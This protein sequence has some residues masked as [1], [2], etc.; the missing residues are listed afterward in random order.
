MATPLTTPDGRNHP[1][2][3]AAIPPKKPSED[4]VPITQRSHCTAFQLATLHS[5][6]SDYTKR[7]RPDLP[8]PEVAFC[9]C[10][11]R[12]RSFY[13]L[14][15]D[16][17]RFV[18]Q[19]VDLFSSRSQIARVPEDVTPPIDLFTGNGD[20]PY[21]SCLFL[22]QTGATSRPEAGALPPA[23]DAG[24]MTHLRDSKGSG[25]ERPTRT[26]AQHAR[27]AFR[28]SVASLGA[29]SHPTT[30]D[31]GEDHVGLYVIM[32]GGGN[33]ALNFLTWMLIRTEHPNGDYGYPQTG[34]GQ[35]C[36]Q[37]SLTNYFDVAISTSRSDAAG[38]F[39]ATGPSDA[40]IDRAV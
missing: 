40:D 20:M 23:D 36:Y 22:Q 12:D 16:C 18:Q 32:R 19:R 29:S 28:P 39:G 14:V 2:W 33:G 26:H 3:L 17:P 1:L 10:S 31:S 13:H 30:L 15:Y 27:Q 9:P 37:S 25:F 6:T 4:H 24:L 11:F 34:G 7:H 38:E 21:A 35:T 8:P 5:F